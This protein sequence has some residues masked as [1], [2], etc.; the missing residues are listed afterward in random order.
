[1]AVQNDLMPTSSSREWGLLPFEES[2][3]LLTPSTFL[4]SSPFRMMRR[5]Q[6]EMDKMWSQL[7]EGSQP[8][9]ALWEPRIDVTEEPAQWNVEVDLPGV[10]K[11][12]ITVDVRDNQLVIHAEMKQDRREDKQHYHRRERRYG[13]YE[14]RLS[15]P[16]DIKDEEI[17]SKFKDGVLTVHIPKTEQAQKAGRQIPIK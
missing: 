5:M 14:R 6:E 2:S 12:N 9:M 7:A 4:S 16:K 10:N 13:S 15:L 11:E 8:D 17:T 1:M 3:S